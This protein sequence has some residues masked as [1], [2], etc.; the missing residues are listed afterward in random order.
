VSCQQK[1]EGEYGVYK[2]F[3]ENEANVGGLPAPYKEWFPQGIQHPAVRRRAAIYW[4]A[5][6][7]NQLRFNQICGM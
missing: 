1:V 2:E 6:A 5:Q 7:K 4:P 3:E